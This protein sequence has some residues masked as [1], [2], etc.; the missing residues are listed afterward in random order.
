MGRL[1]EIAHFYDPEE[2]YCAK[3]FLLAHGIQTI[4]QNEH[5]V[6][7][8]PAL[9][10]AL[11]GYRMLALSEF[12]ETAR[13]ALESIHGQAGEDDPDPIQKTPHNWLWLPIAFLVGI[14]FVPLLKPKWMLPFQFLILA[15]IGLFLIIF[16]NRNFIAYWFLY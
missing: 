2:A 10:F 16:M 13:E 7:V 14:P 11:G 4:F 6:T 8:D 3:G 5:Y 1:V 15:T 9:R 12:E